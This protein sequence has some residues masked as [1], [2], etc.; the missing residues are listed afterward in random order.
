MKSLRFN[1]EQDVAPVAQEVVDVVAAGGLACVPC[2]GTYRLLADIV[3]R[4][5]GAHPPPSRSAYMEQA[6]EPLLVS[7]GLDSA[8]IDELRGQGVVG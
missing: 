7:L 6:L 3:R 5:T 4:H 8:D 2:G 1:G